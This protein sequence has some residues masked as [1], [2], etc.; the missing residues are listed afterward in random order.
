MTQLERDVEERGPRAALLLV[1]ENRG[2]KRERRLAIRWRAELAQLAARSRSRRLRW[3][4]PPS[5]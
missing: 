5:P 4:T 3:S 2:T 1:A